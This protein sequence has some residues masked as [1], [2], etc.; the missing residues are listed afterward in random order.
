[1]RPKSLLL[2]VVALLCGL[3]ASFMIS[4]VL[5]TKKADDRPMKQV[6]VA[7]HNIPMHTTITP[8]ML[9][10]EQW[11]AEKVPEDAVTDIEKVVGMRTKVIVVS[12]Y[13]ITPNLLLG[14]GERLNAANFIP[15]GCRIVPVEVD[16]AS[17]GSEMILPGDRVDIIMIY[18]QGNRQG[19]QPKAK[20]ILQNISVF[21]VD[22]TYT[23]QDVEDETTMQ[24]KTISLLLNQEQT[25]EVMLAAEI[26]KLRLSLRNTEDRQ[27]TDLGESTTTDLLSK[28]QKKKFSNQ[29]NSLFGAFANLAKRTKKEEKKASDQYPEKYSVRLIEGDVI[30]NYQLTK[31]KNGS[32]AL[33]WA[34]QDDATGQG[35]FLE[36]DYNQLGFSVGPGKNP[37]PRTKTPSG[38]G[39]NPSIPFGPGSGES[40]PTPDSQGPESQ[41][42]PP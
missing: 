40:T 19:C 18:G 32:G 1:M 41:E 38:G 4:S 10:M 33:D 30:H 5:A 13:P 9:K 42:V 35:P 29:I 24:G 16:E 26:G 28:Q 11:P 2:L 23:L 39:N 12:N 20:T 15:P 14:K 8:E 17:G 31:K 22:S 7:K 27:V 3:V 37:P 6:L 21:A 25:Q 36:H 34:V